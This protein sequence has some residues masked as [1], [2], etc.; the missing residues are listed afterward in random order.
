[1]AIEPTFGMVEPSR[2]GGIAQSCILLE[3]VGCSIEPEENAIRRRCGVWF[4]MTK[5][6]LS[7]VAGGVYQYVCD[8]LD[9]VLSTY[10]LKTQNYFYLLVRD[11][12]VECLFLFK[13]LYRLFLVTIRRN[14]VPPILLVTDLKN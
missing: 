4:I 14:A 2:C 3:C 5:W 1:M 11:S 12:H 13:D 6:I 9:P 8:T 10:L 7:P